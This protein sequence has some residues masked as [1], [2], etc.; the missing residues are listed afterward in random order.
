MKYV[1]IKNNGDC[2]LCGYVWQV[3]RAIHKY[4]NRKYYIDFSQGCKYE[5]ANITDTRNVWEYY[6]KQPGNST[7]P[8]DSDI[9]IILESI[10]DEP[11]SEFRDIY[12]VN[13][14]LE[15]VSNRRYEFNK[16]ITENI[17]LLPATG[18]KIQKFITEN[19]TNKRVLGVHFRGTDHPDKQSVFN[20]FQSIKNKAANYDIIFCA[21]DE[22]Y[23]INALKAVF[24][25]KVVSYNSIRSESEQPLH[26]SNKP[27]FKI[28]ED[29]IIETYIMANTDFLFCCSN[30]NVNYLARAINPKLESIAL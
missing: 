14:T 27:K 20:Y 28:G 4:P 2:G 11:E 12:M 7:Y 16:I 26:Y 5:D 6:F 23:R 9:E 13:P 15:Y 10:I 25:K 24:G 29:V 30:S 21:S 3:L 19:F 8:L 17:H 22:K 1:I 18:K